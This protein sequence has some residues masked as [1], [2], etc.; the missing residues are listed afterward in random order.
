MRYRKRGAAVRWENGTIIKV[1]ECGSAEERDGL[2]LCAPERGDYLEAPDA[3]GVIAVAAEVMAMVPAAVTVERLIITE[4]TAEHTAGGRVW[5]ERLRRVHL[6]LVRDSLRVMLDL[7]TPDHS[8]EQVC[9][10][11]LRLG[12]VDDHV[13]QMRVA[14]H[15]T[16]ALLPSFAG[17]TPPGARLMQT[18]GG[19]DGKGAGIAEAV[20][21]HPPWPNWYRPSYRT[22]PVRLPLN[23]RI[24]CD[25]ADMG[26][27]PAAVALVDDGR[28]LI[29]DGE[30]AWIAPF[31]I[32]R[33]EAVS[34][35]RTW[36]PYG[37]GAFGAEMLLSAEC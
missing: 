34:R 24:D 13:P 1:L 3:D 32:A 23:L 33:I 12:R 5:C 26:G 27:A 7:E 15:V 14:P 8:I 21:E 19:L 30:R 16:A 2:F 29:D 35:E 25:A 17:A 36:Y 9:A 18:A 6:A 37:G 10:A 28:A 4:G 11:L 20:I 31:R 22:R